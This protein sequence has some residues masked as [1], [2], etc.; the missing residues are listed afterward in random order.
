MNKT[1]V[2]CLVLDETSDE[3]PPGL[4]QMVFGILRRPPAWQRHRELVDFRSAVGPSAETY[5][6]VFA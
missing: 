1:Y 4:D 3:F 5:Q 6:L 2:I